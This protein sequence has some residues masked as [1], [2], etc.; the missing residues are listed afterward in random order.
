MNVLDVPEKPRSF[1]PDEIRAEYVKLSW[2]P[3]EDDG[4]TPISGYQ[5]R[6]LDLEAGG[7]WI[8]VADVRRRL[9]I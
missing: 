4:G 9:G 1:H 8:A 6:M 7:E 5:V 2:E 3:P